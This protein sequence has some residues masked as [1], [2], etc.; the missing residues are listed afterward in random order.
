MSINKI[1][2][3]YFSILILFIF[4]ILASYRY[5]YEIPNN[6]KNLQHYQQKELNNLNFIFEKNFEQIENVN[7][8]YSTW[9]DS[10][11]YLI[12]RNEYYTM[13]YENTMLTS[14]KMDMII[15]ADNNYN[16]IYNKYYDYKLNK[17]FNI[18]KKITLSHIGEMYPDD[19]QDK[20][21]KNGYIYIN[22]K[23]MIYSSQQVR[24]TNK[25]GDNIGAIIFLKELGEN[26]FLDI[27]KSTNLK[28]SIVENN[29]VNF[30]YIGLNEKNR[31][32]DELVFNRLRTLKNV[33]DENVL[34]INIEH[35]LQ[36]IKQ[37]FDKSFF[38][39]LASI[40]FSIFIIQKIINKTFTQP[41][42]NLNT[43]ITYMR[44][45]KELKKI[46]YKSKVLEFQK[47]IDNFNNLTDEIVGKNAKI[48]VLN[49]T[50]QLT[51]LKNKSYFEN[52]IQELFELSKRNRTY[53]GYIL[54]NIDNFK[55]YSTEL[56][57]DKSDLTLNKISDI[58]EQSF[59]YENGIVTRFKNKEFLVAIETKNKSDFLNYCESIKCEL[60]REKIETNANQKSPYIT[61]SSGCAIF[62]MNDNSS[63]SSDKLLNEA[64]KNVL[65]LKKSNKDN[66]KLTDLSNN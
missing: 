14:L 10:Y 43:L 36:D 6:T 13:N 65:E 7:Y 28:I 15:I 21:S 40:V 29:D 64:E 47:T 9:N 23:Y 61:V 53:I 34:L 66:Y 48:E 8:Y 27:E 12:H 50:D 32:E 22:G 56:G 3:I 24:K 45:N 54:V 59:L 16:L 60:I 31:F 5:F 55:E 11:E 20:L 2:S 38:I 35:Q 63:I 19:Q 17:S 4:S 51:K 52:N 58:I 39:L 1:F 37:V 30:N 49:N 46:N 41:I 62:K 57:K 33:A 18:N 42:K 25:M 44:N 26:F